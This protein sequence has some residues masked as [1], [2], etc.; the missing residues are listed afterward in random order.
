VENLEWRDERSDPLNQ[1]IQDAITNGLRAQL[2]A[3]SMVT[4][5]YFVSLAFMPETPSRM[6]GEVEDVIEI[7]T[8]PP[9]LQEIGA[10]IRSIVDR[11]NA[12]Q[13]EKILDSL[14]GTLDAITELSRAPEIKQALVSFDQTLRDVDTAV[15]GI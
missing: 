3:D 13:F 10:G 2:E 11:I 12:Y 6:H 8:I 7:P 14:H 15:V 5:I 4:G 9:P 1:R